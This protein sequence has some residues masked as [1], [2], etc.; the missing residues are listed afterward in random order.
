MKYKDL[1]FKICLRNFHRF[2]IIVINLVFISQISQAQ[3]F[4]N[5]ANIK[6][7]LD[8]FEIG[9]NE[10]LFLTIDS[11][12]I[13]DSINYSSVKKEFHVRKTQSW[14]TRPNGVMVNL[15]TLL[16]LYPKS[17][18]KKFIGNVII[19]TRS[20]GIYK[21]PGFVVTVNNKS[22]FNEDMSSI[23][24]FIKTE[25]SSS[26]N[27]LLKMKNEKKMSAQLNQYPVWLHIP[28]KTYY[29]FEAIPVEIFWYDPAAK[30]QPKPICIPGVPQ[31]QY[32]FLEQEVEFKDDKKWLPTNK[33]GLFKILACKHVVIPLNAE[34]ITLGKY[35]L[36][37]GT[38]YQP[39]MPIFTQWEKITILPLPENN[40][41]D[42]FNMDVGKFS[43][44]IN[45]PKH[46]KLIQSNVFTLQI[47]LKGT[48][49]EPR[50]SD[51]ELSNIT[52]RYQVIDK[53]TKVETNYSHNQL[54]FSRYYNFKLL[55]HQSGK[56]KIGP[57]NYIYF[58]PKSKE[59]ENAVSNILK[60]NFHPGLTNTNIST[61][62]ILPPNKY[63]PV[64]LNV[65]YGFPGFNYAYKIDPFPLFVLL[66]LLL[67]LPI[68]YYF[69]WKR[70]IKLNS[71]L[72][73]LRFK[74][75]KELKNF[76]NK[77]HNHQLNFKLYLELGSLYIKIIDSWI[78]SKYSLR[79]HENN[80]TIENLRQLNNTHSMNAINDIYKIKRMKYIPSPPA[81]ET[82]KKDID[83]IY[84][85]LTK[86]LRQ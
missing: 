3:Y 22:S 63:K 10:P 48:G 34:I 8:K 55:T 75:F 41:P 79:S 62:R 16:E 30:R 13:I 49:W 70:R 2:G 43:L 68:L 12:A 69:G 65:E 73:Y 21:P 74:K 4:N 51:I 9:I 56:M 53:Q 14:G 15:G 76:I 7:E 67:L 46:S 35:V 1:I 85:N 78:H 18:G 25:D 28:K 20:Q 83:K 27:D 66:V 50:A 59:Y 84:K 77:Q 31:Y 72:N 40:K 26:I 80:Q 44:E 5:P 82:M 37:Y 81:I 58:N 64:N 57:L 47:V 6:L 86:I 36:Q 52:S 32:N 17:I 23:D 33:P 71:K 54:A 38:R 11:F 61:I 19:N 29:Q 42:N 24:P 45:I 60:I 39:R